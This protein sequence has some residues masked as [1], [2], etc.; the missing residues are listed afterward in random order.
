MIIFHCVYISVITNWILTVFQSILKGLAPGVIDTDMMASFT[1]EDKAA[2]A[3]E[4]PVGRLGTAEEVAKLLL[5]LAGED[6]GYITGQVFGV[7]G[8]LVI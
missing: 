3:E 6:A 2:L 8:G 7:N 4:T 5:Y 1:A